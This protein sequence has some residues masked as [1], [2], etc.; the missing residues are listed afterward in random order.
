V[1]VGTGSSTIS[2]KVR[3]SLRGD[4]QALADDAVAVLA[5]PLVRSVIRSLIAEAH[6]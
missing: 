6:R 3:A 2:G 5:N 4:L 1:A